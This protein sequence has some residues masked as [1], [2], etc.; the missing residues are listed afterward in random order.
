[1]AVVSIFFFFQPLKNAGLPQNLQFLKSPNFS[2]MGGVFDLAVLLGFVAVFFGSRMLFKK[3]EKPNTLYLS[4]VFACVIAF[5]LALYS[6]FS[7]V[8]QGQSFLLPPYRL[9]WYAAV[10]TLKNPITALFGVGVDNF[11]SIFTLVKDVAYNQSNLWQVNSF[12]IS[13]SALFTL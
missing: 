11:S 7:L 10:E 8:A 13:R 4:A 5:V 3:S 1:L 12:N 2:P 9:S 6:V